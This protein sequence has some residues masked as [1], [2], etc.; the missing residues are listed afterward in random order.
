MPRPAKRNRAA[1][2]LVESAWKT[3]ALIDM[4]Q[5]HHET[6]VAE[7]S[8]I[9]PRGLEQVSD[10]L[11]ASFHALTLAAADLKAKAEVLR[12]SQRKARAQNAEA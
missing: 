9:G 2:E 3:S 11:W 8:G 12:A 6:D 10:E 1:D 5:R 4:L 7:L